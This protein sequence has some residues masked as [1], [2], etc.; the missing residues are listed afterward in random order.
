M[1]FFFL[2][3][4]GQITRLKRLPVISREHFRKNRTNYLFGISNT[5][6]GISNTNLQIGISS[7]SGKGCVRNVF[8][9]RLRDYFCVYKIPIVI[10]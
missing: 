8:A 10:I 1:K 6:F 7:T 9:A 5:F 4:F 2:F 3:F